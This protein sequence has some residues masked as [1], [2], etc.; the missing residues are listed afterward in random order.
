MKSSGYTAKPSTLK[1]ACEKPPISQ[2]VYQ[3][4]RD[5]VV[6]NVSPLSFWKTKWGIIFQK[7]WGFFM[8]LLIQLTFDIWLKRVK[9]KTFRPPSQTL[10]VIASLFILC[11]LFFHMKLYKSLSKGIAS[12]FGNVNRRKKIAPQLWIK[13]H[14]LEDLNP[15]LTMMSIFW[16]QNP[17]QDS[18]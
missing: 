12:G 8:Y 13:A 6:K 15:T 11:G 1:P 10:L 2:E 4:Y 3:Q 7:R 18:N 5:I 9:S 14:F 16:G 17:L